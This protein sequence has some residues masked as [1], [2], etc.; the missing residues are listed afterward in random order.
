METDETRI[1]MDRFLELRLARDPAMEDFLDEDVEWQ[2]PASTGL[3]PF[4][5]RKQVFEMFTGGLAAQVL[6]MSHEK[7]V[8]V[9]V[10]VDGD[11]AA[12]EQ[13]LETKTNWGAEY[14][15]EYC[16]LY[17]WRDGKIV[18]LREYADTLHAAR[19]FGKQLGITLDEVP[20]TPDR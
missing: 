2:L 15:N 12:V 19:V 4:R 9:R 8:V 6:D 16:W 11:T 1:L 5:G 17:T 3:A 14:V 20:E 7:R 18:R 10:I 13:R